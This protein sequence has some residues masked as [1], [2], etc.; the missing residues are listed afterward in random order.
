M[1]D[2]S[3]FQL[4]NVECP[5]VHFEN[6]KKNCWALSQCTQKMNSFY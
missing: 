3:N 1:V 6:T 5:F 4:K 2:K